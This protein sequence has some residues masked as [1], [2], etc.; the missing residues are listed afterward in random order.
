MCG[1]QCIKTKEEELHLHC[2]GLVDLTHS[3][4]QIFELLISRLK[5]IEHPHEADV[6]N[7]TVT[8]D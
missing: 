7:I 2:F 1:V 3:R 4:D 8:E 6:D 5:E